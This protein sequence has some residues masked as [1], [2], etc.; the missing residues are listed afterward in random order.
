MKLLRKATLL[1]T[2]VAL[3]IV[4]SIFMVQTSTAFATA[5]VTVATFEDIDFT[6]DDGAV[7]SKTLSMDIDTISI[8]AL[9]EDDTTET[10]YLNIE[11]ITNPQ[12]N[13]CIPFMSTILKKW[14]AGAANR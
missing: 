1:K 8:S 10:V 12:Y 13:L 11:G 3:A 5:F 6:I 2:F 4:F 9:C 7:E 14:G